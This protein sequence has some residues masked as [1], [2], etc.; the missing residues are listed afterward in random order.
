MRAIVGGRHA[1]EQKGAGIGS[2]LVP[3]QARLLSAA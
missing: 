3:E 1:A 2:I